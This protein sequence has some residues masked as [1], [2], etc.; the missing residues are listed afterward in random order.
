MEVAYVGSSCRLDTGEDDTGFRSRCAC[1]RVTC[2][3]TAAYCECLSDTS[4]ATTEHWIVLFR[5]S[6]IGSE[7]DWSDGSVARVQALSCRLFVVL[8]TTTNRHG[9]T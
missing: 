2:C 6:T 8:K 9:H 7:H 1:A 3:L 4:R 5:E